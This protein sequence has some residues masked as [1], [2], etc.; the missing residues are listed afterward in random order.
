MQDHLPYRLTHLVALFLLLWSGSATLVHAQEK[1]WTS[2]QQAVIDAAKNGP[3]GIETDF[4]AWAGGYADD[5][6]Y[7][8]VG[9][10]VTRPRDEHMELV[11][12]YIDAGNR[13]TAFKFEPV[14]VVVRGDV[15]LLRLI[16]S[17]E[18]RS[19][20]GAERVVRYA[21]ASMLMR[22]EG[23]WKMLATNIVYLD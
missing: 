11:R 20:E 21:S 12:E 7:W 5:W 17:E 6:T 2:E 4:D 9:E 13:P 16:A 3:M 19:A 10:P 23:D 18:L 22:E 8:R 1:S 15:A 14:D